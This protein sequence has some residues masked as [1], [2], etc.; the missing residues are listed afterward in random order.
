MS[1]DRYYTL[2]GGDFVRIYEEIEFSAFWV[3]LCH[4]GGD[5]IDERY[6]FPDLASA[7]EFYLEGWKDRQFVDETMQAWTTAAYTPEGA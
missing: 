5:L 7:T 1:I 3:D 4:G 6:Y 2:L